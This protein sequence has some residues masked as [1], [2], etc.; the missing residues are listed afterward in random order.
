[1]KGGDGEGEEES[2]EY[3]RRFHRSSFTGWESA[4]MKDRLRRRRG[5][6]N[7]VRSFVGPL[8]C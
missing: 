2:G 1:L 3:G 5:R 8:T 6:V 4:A 7:E